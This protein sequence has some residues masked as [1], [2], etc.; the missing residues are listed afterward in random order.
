V[1][2]YFSKL[3]RFCAITTR[4]E[5]HDANYRALIKLTSFRIWMRFY[6]SVT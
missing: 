2:R 3:K 6:K 5:K 4:Y 1:E